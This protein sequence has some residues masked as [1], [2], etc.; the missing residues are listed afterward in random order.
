MIEVKTAKVFSVVVLIFFSSDD[1][2]SE[3]NW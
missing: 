2:E 1:S 3:L